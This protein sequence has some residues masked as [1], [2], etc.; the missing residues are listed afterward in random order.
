MLL[1]IVKH[2]NKLPREALDTLF[3]GV[4]MARLDGQGT[5][6]PDLVGSNWIRTG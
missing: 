2:W 4:F 1:R 6:Q 5:G 3:L